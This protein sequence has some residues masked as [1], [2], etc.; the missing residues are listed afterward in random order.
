MLALIEAPVQYV[1]PRPRQYSAD[2][3]VVRTIVRCCRTGVLLTVRNDRP[4]PRGVGTCYCASA[5]PQPAPSAVAS[6]HSLRHA[7]AGGARSR[8]ISDR[9]S[10]ATRSS[11]GGEFHP[12]A[13]TKP[14]VRLSPHPASTFQPTVGYQSATDTRGSGLAARAVRANALRRFFDIATACISVSP[15]GREPR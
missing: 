13:L 11:S 8:A 12:S 4:P 3:R 15:I 14:D 6:D 10:L 7:G 5:K 9:M 2:L 1:R